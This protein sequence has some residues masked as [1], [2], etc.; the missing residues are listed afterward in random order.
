MSLTMEIGGAT[1][2]YGIIGHPVAHSLS[3]LFQADFFRAFA[4]DGVYVP[5]PVAPVRLAQALA[6]LSAIG[7]EGFNVTV[8]HKEAVHA[9]LGGD[10]DAVAIG[11]VNTVRRADD[12]WTA[13]N[14][15]WLGFAGVFAG[16]GIDAGAGEALVFG[17]GGTARAAVHALAKAGTPAVHLCNR[18]P[19]RLDALLAHARSRYPGT[20]FAAVAWEQGA[21]T[22]A[23]A[24]SPVVINTTSIGIGGAAGP[25]PFALAGDGV[26]IDAVYVADGVT[27]FAA[28]AGGRLAVDGLPM[29]VAQGAASFAFWF[30]GH[31]PDRLSALRRLERR[32]GRAEAPICWRQP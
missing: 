8:P 23:A 9:H 1:K 2:V 15:D 3:P 27:P 12:G 32:L 17:A 29:L 26:A 20:R 24:A 14:T 7:V 22:A 25:F 16:L 30:P 13:T 4:I 19:E 5:F 21:V 31:A 10:A 28:V 6:G 18:S 11:A